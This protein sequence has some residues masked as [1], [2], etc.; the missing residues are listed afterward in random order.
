MLLESDVKSAHAHITD[1][2]IGLRT[3]V[4]VETANLEICFIMTEVG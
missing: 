1:D 2:A 4:R 3:L